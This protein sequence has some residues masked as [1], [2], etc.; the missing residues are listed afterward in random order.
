[1][2]QLRGRF[3]FCLWDQRNGRLLLARDR[4]GK[5]PLNYMLK[6]GSLIFG[7]EIKSI[8]QDPEISRE[9][10]IESL[11]HYLTYQYVPPPETMFVGIKKLP[12]AHILIWEKGKINIERYWNLNYQNKIQLSEEEYCER[13]LNLLTEAVKIRMISDVPL[14]AFLSGGIDSSAIVA[15]MS[16]LSSQPVKTFSIGFE[17]ESFNELK[18][19]RRIAKMFATDHH[20]YIVKPD[21]LEVLPNLIWHFNEPFADSSAIPTYYLSKMTRQEVT[22]ALNGDGGDETFAG[23]DRYIANKIANVY[24][25]IPQCIRKNIIASF[26]S[27]FP[28]S[29]RKKDFFKRLKRF[30]RTDGLSKE[31]R[32]ADWMS[33]FDNELKINLYSEELKSKLKGVDSWD[34]IVDTYKQSD[35]KDFIDST[36]FVDIMTYLPNDLLVKV[37]ITSMANSL[38]A[39]SPFLDHKL[40]EFAALIPSGLKLKGRITKYILK[41]ALGKILPKEILQRRKSGFGVPIGTWFREKL[42]NYAY[43]VLLDEKSIKRNYFKEEAVK[44]LLDEH[45]SGK[46]DHGPR[47][48][49]LLNLEL[50]HQM[51]IDNKIINFNRD[52]IR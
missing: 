37:D 42:K 13:I 12:P 52:I 3:A 11:H 32:Y 15:L 5:K 20:E 34:Y 19:A 46:F 44:K 8:L 47:I 45:I 39:R 43:E 50:W 18:Y 21:A 10:N 24:R 30:T 27:N 4:V 14:G 25:F 49:S 2:K 29:T 7:S 16:R 35:A 26:V 22:V 36:L 41:K 23:Y 48:W 9:V 40:M 17:E 33:I 6:N 51:F 38:E 28:E 31:R 1:M